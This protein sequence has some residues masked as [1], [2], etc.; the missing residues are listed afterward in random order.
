MQILEALTGRDTSFI[1][2]MEDTTKDVT[3]IFGNS[4]NNLGIGDGL[5]S[6]LY[7]NSGG[8]GQVN[9]QR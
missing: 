5:K 4:G 1:S 7:D 6:S 3:S 8:I 9:S 2:I